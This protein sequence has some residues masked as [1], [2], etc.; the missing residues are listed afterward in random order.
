MSGWTSPRLDGRVGILLTVTLVA[1]SVAVAVSTPTEHAAAAS[2]PPGFQEEIV[3]SGLT[4]PTAVRFSPDGRAL[5]H[6]QVGSL[7]SATGSFRTR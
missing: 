2:L 4:E 7:S 5:S 1:S 6:D 3:I